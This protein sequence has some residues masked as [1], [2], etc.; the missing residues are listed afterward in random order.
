[1]ATD[2]KIFESKKIETT[3][4]EHHRMIYEMTQGIFRLKIEQYY[5]IKNGKAYVITFTA[6]SAKFDAF[7]KQGEQVLDSFAFVR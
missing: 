2:G 5:F 7:K 6:E 1:M 3:G 4:K